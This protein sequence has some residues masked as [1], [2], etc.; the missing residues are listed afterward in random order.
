MKHTTLALL[1]GLLAPGL[2]AATPAEML[3]TYRVEA[4]R[5]V[6]GF[7]PDA[8]RGGEFYARRFA[9]S[10]KMP[11]C[12]SCHGDTPTQTGAHAVTGKAIKPLAPSANPER[13]TDRA[14]VEKWFGR[15]CKEVVGR[16]CTAVEKADFIAFLQEAR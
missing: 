11:S 8:A 2:Q 16:D 13:F 3:E 7:Q 4:A 5:Q 1:T 15:N 9:V 10:A 14:K 6:A 12:A